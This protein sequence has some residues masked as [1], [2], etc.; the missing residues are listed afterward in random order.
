LGGTVIVET[1]FGLPGLGTLLLG[2]IQTKDLAMVQ[3]V[4]L[5][6]AVV[7]VVANAAVDSLYAVLDPRVKADRVA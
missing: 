4:V 6:I 3:G 5:F 1:L 2:A 7:Y